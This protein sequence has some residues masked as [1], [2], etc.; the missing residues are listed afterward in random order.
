MSK[1]RT[2]SSQLPKITAAVSTVVVMVLELKKIVATWLE[3]FKNFP[4]SS[5]SLP[6]S[7]FLIRLSIGLYL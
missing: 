3:K 4:S 1:E 7:F 6:F 5:T 2:E